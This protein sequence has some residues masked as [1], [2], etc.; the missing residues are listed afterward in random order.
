M[1][2]ARGEMTIRRLPQLPN[3]PTQGE[4]V[5]ALESAPWFGFYAPAGMNPDLVK[6]L[7]GLLNRW[8]V[9]LAFRHEHGPAVDAPVAPRR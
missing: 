2:D 6:R 5:F 9:L 8:L 1:T 7:N 4:Q 3:V